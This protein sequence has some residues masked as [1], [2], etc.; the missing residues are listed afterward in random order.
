MA[1][2]LNFDKHMRRALE[3]SIPE[4]KWKPGWRPKGQP[5]RVDLA[6]LEGERPR[7]LVEAELKKDDSAANVIKVWRWARD[8]KNAEPILFV[9]GFSRWYWETKARIREAARFAGERMAE[10]GLRIDYKQVP[11]TYR[12]KTGRQVHYRP[13]GGREGAGRLRQAAQGL[14]KAVA[15]LAG[16]I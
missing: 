4:L 13:R 9:H 15:R 8:S 1:F 3:E 10:D 12:S 6:G 14:A 16:P 2:A 7:V 5:W 11:I